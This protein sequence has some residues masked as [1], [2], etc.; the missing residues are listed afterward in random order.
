MIFRAP[1]PHRN[2]PPR[3]HQERNPPARTHLLEEVVGRHLEQG[4][5]DQEHHERDRVLV[6][7][8]VRLGEEII[9]RGRVENLGVA[10]V[11]P[12][13]IAEEVDGRGERDDAPVLLSH[14]GL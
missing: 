9:P 2:R 10:D 7:R 5:R 6:R 13:E 4:I 12:V 8:H 11:R 3:E 1:K 14:E